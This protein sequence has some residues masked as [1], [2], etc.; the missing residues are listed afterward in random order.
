[1]VYDTRLWSP[2]DG[3]ERATTPAP[4]RCLIKAP[5]LV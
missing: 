1:M 5:W 4:N 2:R 3:P